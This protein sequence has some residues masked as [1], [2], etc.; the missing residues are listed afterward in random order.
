VP[1]YILLDG[2][3]EQ[4]SIS[5]IVVNQPA[6]GQLAEAPDAQVGDG[7][8]GLIGLASNKNTSSSVGNSS[9][10]VPQFQDSIYGQWLSQNPTAVNFTFGMQ[11][12]VPLNIPRGN[13]SQSK[14]TSMATPAGDPGMLHWLQPDTTAYDPSKVA[15]MNAGTANS[16]SASMST[17]TSTDWYVSLD[18]WVLDAGDNHVSN[19]R[20]VVATVDPLYSDLYLPQDQASLIRKHIHPSC[21]FF[22]IRMGVQ[23]MPLMDPSCALI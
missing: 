7:L 9:Q 1:Q 4:Y 19:T 11:L 8:S 21:R 10:Y 16:S 15:W 3:F 17:S 18:G 12:G 6:Q 2:C 23:T 5:V 14:V 20:S 22:L 13:T